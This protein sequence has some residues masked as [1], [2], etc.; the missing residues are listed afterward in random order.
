MSM[1]CKLEWIL[2]AFSGSRVDLFKPDS[3]YQLKTF[4]PIT[5]IHHIEKY[6]WLFVIPDDM[7]VFKKKRI[8][9]MVT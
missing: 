7:L 3:N 5:L 1:V 6:P 2:N 8:H 9:A 4:K